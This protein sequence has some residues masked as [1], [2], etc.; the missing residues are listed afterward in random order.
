MTRGEVFTR[1]LAIAGSLGLIYSVIIGWQ[2]YLSLPAFLQTPLALL[3]TLVLS[4]FAGV[5]G[6]FFLA[7]GLIGFGRLFK[8]LEV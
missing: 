8:W 2:L 6:V 5:F 4:S 3:A 7:G 1:I